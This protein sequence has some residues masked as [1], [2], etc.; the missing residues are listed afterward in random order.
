MGAYDSYT[1]VSLGDV[2]AQAANIKGAQ[3]KQQLGQLAI[4]QQTTDLNNQQGIQSTLAS[5]PNASVT[6]LQ[7]FGPAGVQASQQL[8]AA[9]LSD[10][11]NHFRTQYQA[12]SA[13]ADSDNPAQTAAQVAPQFAQQYDQVHGPGA[14]EQLA[15][16]PAALK[17]A[18]GQVRDQ[19]LAGL[20]DPTEQYK[21]HAQ[22][23]EDHYK[24]EG[25][26]G[27]QARNANTVSA[28]NARTVFNQQQ[29]NSRAAQSRAVTT[30]GQDLEAAQRGI[31]AGYMKDPTQPTTS[32]ALTPMPGGPHD[33]NAVAGGLDSRSSVM[34]NRVASSANEAVQAI[35]N[36][37]ELPITSSSGWFGSAEPGKGLL[38]SA[39]NVLAQKVTGQ[40]AQD[41]KTMVSGVAR[42]LS[43]IETA[44]LAPNGSIS[45]SMNNLIL[46]EGDTQMTKLRKMAEMRQIVE[47]GLEPQLSN[48]KL[49]PTQKNLI[50]GIISSVQTAVP[51]T[52]HDITQLQ[53]S[54]NPKAT[55]M[56][57]AGQ[58]GLQSS[59]T[60]PSKPATPAA[61]SPSSSAHPPNIQALLD[62]YTP[63]Q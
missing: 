8:S 22:A 13:V 39:K 55:I 27:E 57:F 58:Q 19:A 59:P 32:G 47:Q 24:Q 52:H 2:L 29:E 41:Y 50:Q 63:P 28:D 62:K 23:A 16:N 38:D 1:P 40:D 51:F 42:N 45:Q 21:A 54:K 15:S 20:V 61:A 36:I 14:W 26:G 49:G 18:A 35:K 11:T 30:R 6:D 60:A 7:K 44:G 17:A 10:L 25:P 5:N 43:T 9:H 33:P 4:Q 12:A 34:F 37:G 53:Q 56:D 48:P 31:P 46:N 3:Q